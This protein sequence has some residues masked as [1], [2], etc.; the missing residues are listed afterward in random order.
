MLEKN[1]MIEIRVNGISLDLYEGTTSFI[2][3]VQFNLA[4]LETRESEA[5][6]EIEIPKTKKNINTLSL[7][8]RRIATRED[9][10]VYNCELIVEGVRVVYGTMYILQETKN[11]LTVFVLGERATFFNQLSQNHLNELSV[12]LSSTLTA[13]LLN[14]TQWQ[15]STDFLAIHA[16]GISFDDQAKT[17]PP[18]DFNE[19]TAGVYAFYIKKLLEYIVVEAGYTFDGSNFDSLFDTLVLIYPDNQ[20]DAN[21][22][23]GNT[24]ATVNVIEGLPAIPQKEFFIEILKLFALVPVVNGSTVSFEY[25]EGV[26]NREPLVLKIDKE[27]PVEYYDN[28]NLYAQENE[29]YFQRGLPSDYTT[30]NTA[31]F[32]SNGVEPSKT[33]LSSIFRRVPAG[34]TPRYPF[35]TVEVKTVSDTYTGGGG[36][37]QVYFTGSTSPYNVG[38]FIIVAGE[39]FRIR[40]VSSSN[41][42]L[43]RSVTA[44]VSQ[45]EVQIYNYKAT[46]ENAL[47]GYI[48]DFNGQQ[49]YAY[50]GDILAMTGLANDVSFSFGAITPTNLLTNY[51]SDITRMLENPIYFR[52]YTYLTPIEYLNL[53]VT[54]PIYIE[55][56]GQYFY[57]NK[58]EQWKPNE[59][60]RLELIKI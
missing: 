12:T 57:L 16:I 38:D 24:S 14:N 10:T 1:T 34:G 27:K 17:V 42:T 51:F 13:Q 48:G 43:S 25:I 59:P 11:T 58:V 15:F 41:L 8:S 60:T 44:T 2:N 18:L 21:E 3:K 50:N 7:L 31:T 49:D 40:G 46:G 19:T 53:S 36:T 23:A 32:S 20:V 54:T 4:D 45:S 47:L 29:F 52:C 28:L 26:G 30:G 33:V 56:E 5:T 9:R 22:K 35:Y 55:E 6:Q 39:H 37:N